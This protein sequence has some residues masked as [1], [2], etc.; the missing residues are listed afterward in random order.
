M[1]TAHLTE[2]NP[3]VPGG[4]PDGQVPRRAAAH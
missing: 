4:P 2:T 3:P 1:T